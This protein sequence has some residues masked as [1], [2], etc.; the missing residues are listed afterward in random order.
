MKKC[1][2]Y[3]VLYKYCYDGTKLEPYGIC[4][5]TKDRERCSCCGDE[6][7]CDFYQHVR[8]RAQ[9]KLA[10]YT[11]NQE[12]LMR[13]LLTRSIKEKQELP[14]WAY[15]EICNYYKKDE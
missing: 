7:K 13:R 15:Q 9:Q 8:E 1:N 14:W 3:E 6:L 5:G 2:C 10:A 4:N 11:L 12:T